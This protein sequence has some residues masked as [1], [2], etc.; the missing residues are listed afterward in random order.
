MKK[1][2][3]IAVCAAMLALV[4]SETAFAQPE[5]GSRIDRTRQGMTGFHDPLVRSSP[6]AGLN[7][8]MRCRA[9]NDRTRA[10]NTLSHR[11]MSEEQTESLGRIFRQVEY[12]DRCSLAKDIRYSVSTGPVAGAFAEF[13]LL[14]HYKAEDIEALGKLTDLD[15]QKD[16]MK[17]RNA[18]EL[19]GRCVVR[20]GGERIYDLIDTIPDSEQEGAAIQAV[21]PLLSPCVTDGLEVSFDKTSLRAMLAYGLYRAVHQHAELSEAAE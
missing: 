14:R 8:M 5:T 10:L 20:S 9:E 13:F 21:V 1:L 18:E 19:F 15:W 16:I 2:D 6:R 17:P 12:D 11:Y 3:I 7:A 4:C